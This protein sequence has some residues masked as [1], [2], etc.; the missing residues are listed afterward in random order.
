MSCC[1]NYITMTNTEADTGGGIA[2]PM[3]TRGD[4]IVRDATNATARLAVGTASQVLTSDGTD[5]SWA[6]G[7]SELTLTDKTTSYTAVSGDWINYDLSGAGSAA[8]V[9]LPASPTIGQIVRVTL[10][11]ESVFPAICVHFLRNGA[12]INGSLAAE[13]ELYHTLWKAGDTVTFKCMKNGY[14]T[15]TDRN[16]AN[17][18][19]ARMFLTGNQ[20]NL[21]DV[22]VTKVLLN[23][24]DVDYN[25]DLDITTGHD[26]T[27]PVTGYYLCNAGVQWLGSSL[28]ANKLFV[29]WISS[30]GA[31]NFIAANNHSAVVANF[32][33]DISTVKYLTAGDTITLDAYQACGISTVDVQGGNGTYLDITLLQR[34]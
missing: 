3:T 26:Y 14:W 5:V 2:D 24:V 10:G 16:I 31:P 25:D 23:T 7:G 20:N 34:L 28:L 8:T 13:E 6:A 18:F 9:T 15:T 11:L 22:T 30:S 27:V 4:I 29:M 19:S 33:Q 32:D 12:L 17:R 1:N 21:T